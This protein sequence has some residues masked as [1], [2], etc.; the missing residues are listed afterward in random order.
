MSQLVITL[1]KN[2]TSEDIQYFV[3]AGVSCFRLN[4]ARMRL[5]TLITNAKALRDIGARG[6]THLQLFVDLPGNKVRI[7]SAS[8]KTEVHSGQ[9]IEIGESAALRVPGGAFV[10]SVGVGSRLWVRR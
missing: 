9:V 4:S 5:S 7:S 8:A 2:S 10:E 3:D 6:R 1:P